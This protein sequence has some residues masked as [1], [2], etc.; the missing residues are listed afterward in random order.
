MTLSKYNE[1]MENL[2]ITDEMR[3][4]LLEN[5]EKEVSADGAGTNE[6]GS[7]GSKDE[8]L[9]FQKIDVNEFEK[10][11]NEKES[12]K[13]IKFVA[14]YGSRVAVFALVALGA[15]SVVRLVGLDGRKSMETSAPA[16][17]EETAEAT[18]ESAAGDAYESQDSAVY[19]G[20]ADLFDEEPKMAESEEATPIFGESKATDSAN[21]AGKQNDASEALEPMEDNA[22]ESEATEAAETAD[23]EDMLA[24]GKSAD[25]LTITMAGDVLLHTPVAEAG[26]DENGNYNFDFLFDDT[27]DEIESADLALVNQE[28]ILG[29]KELGVTGYPSFNAPQELGDSLVNAG[30]DVI[31]HATNHALDKGKQGILNTIDFWRNKYSQITVVGINGSQ[32]EYDTVKMVEKNG[33]TV[34]ILN[35]TYGTNGIS[36]PSDM[37][38]AVNTLE[39]DKVISDLKYAEENADFTIV[40][41]HWGTEYNHDL[42]G[43]QEKWTE[44]FRKYGAD[45]VIGTHPHVIEPIEMLED[46]EEGITNNHGD[47]DMLVYYS[48]GNFVN[49]T[50]GTGEGIADRMV[51]GLANITLKRDENG[52]VCIDDYGIRALVCHVQSGYEN[53]SVYPLSEYT[54]AMAEKNEII[55]QDSKFTKEYCEKLCDDIWGNLWK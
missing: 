27:R 20:A 16:A 44:I 37:P 10:K 32:E 52:E 45:L 26:M 29:G 9:S 30:F 28:V 12:G 34:A 54:D 38:Y 40:C 36:N 19:D 3:A 13:I 53:I 33:I 39:E 17:Y 11:K 35:Y 31:C 48:I 43:M 8:P 15:F 21:N 46:N 6:I 25:E 14:R 4:R 23:S 24:V 51:G 47:G 49:W 18:A 5:I 1:V 41:P 2:V 7:D 42:D 50:S 22:I 55:D